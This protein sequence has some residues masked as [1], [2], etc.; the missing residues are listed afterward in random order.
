MEPLDVWGIVGLFLRVAF[1]F[2]GCDAFSRPTL[3]TF[4]PEGL[5]RS[6]SGCN[7][8]YFTFYREQCDAAF[9]LGT[10]LAERETKAAF[11]CS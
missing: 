10:R 5:Q 8:T 9:W 2:S 3:L 11:A 6:E 7:V 1:S 4:R